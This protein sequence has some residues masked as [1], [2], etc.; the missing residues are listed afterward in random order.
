[1]VFRDP[2]WLALLPVLILAGWVWRGLKLGQP[3]R[4][5]ILLLTIFLLMRPQWRR[6]TGGMDLWVLLDRSGSTEAR[7]D[8]GFP[9]WKRLLESGKRR[10]DDEIHFVDYAADAVP[11]ELNAGGP[12]TGSRA[13]TRTGS[14]VQQ[15]LALRDENRPAR[16]LVFTDGFSTEPL[17]GVAEK[18]A[19]AKV[20]L[21]FRLI[22]EADGGDFRLR[23]LQLPG[24]SQVNEP[25]LV[26]VEVSGPKDG[27]VPLIIS[28]NGQRLMDS[29]VV[30]SKG[31]GVARFTDRIATTGAFRYEALITP[32]DDAHPG[33]NRYEGWIEVSGGPRLL[34]VTK[35]TPDP[36]EAVLQGQGF[37]VEVVHEPGKLQA[38]QLSGC[39][40]VIFNNVPAWEVPADFLNSLNFFVNAQGGGLMMAGGKKSFGAGGYFRSPIDELLPVSLELK[41]DQKKLAAAMVIVMDRSGSMAAH[42]GGGTKMDLANEGAARAVE[43]L[44]YQDMVGV[45]AVDSEA[46]EVVGLQQIG[47]DDNRDKMK[48]R[49]RRVRSEGGGIFVYNGLKAGWAALKETSYGTRHI[50]LFADA[51]DAEQPE[52]YVK[53]LTEVT[54][55]GGSVSV[56]ALGQETDS[57][58]A[59]LKDVARRGNGRIFFTDR[60]EDLPNVFTAETVAVARSA[61]VADPVPAVSNGLWAEV[62]GKPLDWL[63]EVDGYNLSYRKD[64]ASQGLISKDEFEAPLVAWGQRGSGRS[65]AVSFPL[66]GEFSERVRGWPKYGDFAQTLGRWLMGQDLPPGLGLKWELTGTELA[67]DLMYDDEWEEKFAKQVPRI[68]LAKGL[69]AEAGPELTWQRMSPGHFRAAMTLEESEVIRGAVQ[70]GAFAIP[71]GPVSA[72]T[73][74]EWTFDPARVD[75]LRQTATESGGQELL[76]LK[77]A[78][79]AP[80]VTQFTDLRGWLLPL[81][82]LLVLLE[83][84]ATRLGWRFAELKL[85]LP[86]R[87]AAAAAAATTTAQK[88]AGRTAFG[89]AKTAAASAAGKTGRMPGTQ[90]AETPTSP[91]EPSLPKSPPPVPAA[92]PPAPSSAA[93]PDADSLAAAAAAE[94][95]RERFARAKKGGG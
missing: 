20:P 48:E 16:I 9:E 32:K 61:F 41:K 83:A 15:A 19:K 60:A 92:P 46:H 10:R 14:A 23:R 53:L 3:L 85:A 13:L 65:A 44:G 45:Y 75:E 81:L 63:G 74:V 95:R 43:L 84:L 40:G 34:L 18:L 58:A 21:D 17:G 52:D 72:G 73:N 94:R 54:A 67:L 27:P 24:R 56:I 2:Q 59:F 37:T 4:A 26:E 11:Q 12:F 35:Y 55:E 25:F 66:G 22:T 86:G 64:W 49:I 88:A 30:L 29:E 71:F 93:V 69:R 68:V 51:A 47:S 28:R 90:V 78:W 76:D 79:K 39:R 6:M 80:P 1:M 31:R 38:G 50:I 57:D 82:L 42:I 5:A 8:Q 62:A 89:A 91:Q 87:N 33:N 70:A 77:D 7:V 36:L